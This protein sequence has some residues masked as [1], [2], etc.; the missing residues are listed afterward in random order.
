[1]ILS[2]SPQPMPF[3]DS[4]EEPLRLLPWQVR[5]GA[6]SSRVQEL[7]F[8]DMRRSLQGLASGRSR[9]A[10]ELVGLSLA[11]QPERRSLRR[12]EV[13]SLAKLRFGKERH[14]AQTRARM[15]RL[16]WA[17]F[18]RGERAE[19]GRVDDDGKT[20]GDRRA[21]CFDAT[22]GPGAFPGPLVFAC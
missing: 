16:L 1:M 4:Y 12:R 18:A 2:R 21:F 22:S 3:G 19:R 5:S 10:Q 7:L 17:R 15:I 13:F 20:R 14:R 6:V 9:Q 11:G 8:A